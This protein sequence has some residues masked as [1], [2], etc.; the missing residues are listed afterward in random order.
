MAAS[1]RFWTLSWMNLN[2]LLLST[3]SPWPEAGFSVSKTSTRA[4]P[5]ISDSSEGEKV[6]PM[7]AQY[8]S[9]VLSSAGNRRILELNRET[10]LV[11]MRERLIRSRSQRHCLS[12]C[13]VEEVLVVKVREA[14]AH[15]QRVP[16]GQVADER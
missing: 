11:G 13:Q 9:M 5:V 8:S 2:W 10:T 16:L 14:L 3:I 4:F 15:E 6:L 1:A 7:M 12:S